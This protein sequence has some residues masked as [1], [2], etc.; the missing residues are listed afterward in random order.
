MVVMIVLVACKKQEATPT[1]P[2]GTP[3]FQTS[4]VEL[5]WQVFD[6]L[7]ANQSV[8]WQVDYI[9]AG[10][11]AL[12]EFAD[13]KNLSSRL[14]ERMKDPNA[15]AYYQSVRAE[16]EDLTIQIQVCSE[17]MD[18]LYVIYPATVFYPIHFVMGAVSTGGTISSHG[19]IVALEM[20][21]KNSNSP[22]DGLGAWEQQTIRDKAY[23]A[24]IVIHEFVHMQQEA[25]SK[26]SIGRSTLEIAIMEGMADFVS[27]HLLAQQAFV[28]DHLH[29]YGDPIE[30]QIW[31]HFQKEMDLDFT[32]TDW[33]YKGNE[34]ANGHLADMGYYVGFK[35]LEAYAS[36]FSSKEEA[37]ANML[38]STDYQEIFQASGYAEKFQD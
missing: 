37:I 17:A 5:F 22:I 4:D 18:A 19:P 26:Q 6:D 8:D 38:G 36:K 14:P 33:L 20:W 13:S 12:K 15:I 7:Q 10:S 2:L 23:L 21:T 34:T 30:E 9:N 3:S 24:S 32:E 1:N 11:E 27:V 25:L 31:S 28:N 35:I 16:T 29:T